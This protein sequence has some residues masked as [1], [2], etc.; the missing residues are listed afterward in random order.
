VNTIVAREKG[1]DE[2]KQVRWALLIGIDKYPYIAQLEGCAHD[3]REMA[4]ILTER[5]GFL[6][7]CMTTLQDEQATRDG[8]L[9]ALDTL[10]SQVAEDD[11]VV[12]HY[13]GHG[14]QRHRQME[15][16]RQAS[17]LEE[18]LVPYDSGHIEPFPNRD[19]S[20]AE[21]CSR[22]TQ[23]TKVTRNVT[24]ILD[25]CHAGTIASHPDIV[26]FA[27][28]RDR[29]VAYEVVLDDGIYGA[30]T[31]NLLRE[32]ESLPPG[33]CPTYRDVFE[34][35]R[36]RVHDCYPAQEPQLEGVWDRELFGLAE[37]M[38]MRFLPVQDRQAG[39]VLF[40]GGATSGVREG[41]VWTIH[42]PQAQPGAETLGR[43]EV[44]E[45]R[46]MTAFARILDEV[47]PGAIGR[48]CRAVQET[49]GEKGGRDLHRRYFRDALAL[50]NDLSR[51]R[52]KVDFNLGHLKNGRWEPLAD[53]EE[54]EE[55]ESLSFGMASYYDKPLYIYVLEFG[56]TGNISQ[57]YPVLGVSDP[58]APGRR[59]EIGTLTDGL[60]LS[61][62]DGALDGG[63]E[64]LKLFAA[65]REMDLSMHFQT[66]QQG[67]TRGESRT[68][69]TEAMLDPVRSGD[70]WIT[71][72]RRFRLKRRSGGPVPGRVTRSGARAMS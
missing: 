71:I 50:R 17:S 66:A 65:T 20:S 49:A 1:R 24:L 28:C 57:V 39:R 47:Q 9:M 14:S 25:C 51:L 21:F 52:G 7:R 15:D 60:K 58:L 40:G 43:V 54:I 30:L 46:G 55:G 2:P 16:I 3:I 53:G 10:A 48:S 32:L 63:E 12:I 26:V 62:P 56:L 11:A 31:W 29:E 45:V 6:P 44:T 72:E 13:S 18:T 70:D 59:I 22:L 19:I 8:I 61:V 27:A 69:D 23:I 38:P 4:R 35:I 68:R 67:A 64:S 36:S 37:L 34:A 41:S 5:F 42:P 33:A